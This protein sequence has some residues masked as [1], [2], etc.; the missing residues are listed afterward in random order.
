MKP[1][2][3]FTGFP[4]FATAGTKTYPGDTKNA[5]GFVP[6]DTFPA[7]WANYLFYRASKNVT[8]LN[9]AVSSIWTELTNLLTEWGI[10][11]TEA[12]NE[13]LKTAI[14]KILPQVTE[15]TTA[16]ATGAKSITIANDTLKTGKMYAVTFSNGNE[17]GDGSSTYPTLSI[18]GGTAYPMYDA[19][20]NYLK[21]GS[22]SAGATLNLVFTGTKFVALNIN[23]E[24]SVTE[25][26][27]MPVTSNAVAKAINISDL[28][29]PTERWLRFVGNNH[30]ALKIIKGVSIKVGIHTFTTDNDVIFDL[31]SQELQGG[32]NY[33][34]YLNWASGNVWSLTVDTNKTADT[35][36]SRLIGRFHTLCVSVSANQT[37]LLPT[38]TLSV[39]ASVNTSPYA[40]DDPD[41]VEFYTKSVISCS[42]D[43]QLY[44]ST[45]AHPLAGF[46]AGDILPEAVWCLTFKPDTKYEDA[47]FYDPITGRAEDIYLQSGIGNSTRSAYNA[48]HAVSR[49]QWNHQSDM[50]AVGKRL[51]KD[52]EFTACSLGSPQKTNIAGSSDKTTVGGHSDTGGN[53]MISMWGA[54][55]CCGYLWQ[56]LEEYIHTDTS[57]GWHTED[58]STNAPFGQSYWTVFA[59]VAGGPWG[60]GAICGSRCRGASDPRSSVY[61]SVGGRGSSLVKRGA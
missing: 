37:M 1:E 26:N 53:R 36:D 60:S 44:K 30:K 34:V 23:V 33:Y 47:M 31:T 16:A 10:T 13:Q 11:P 4:P 15:C 38:E 32:T 29:Y 45:F 57:T 51:L 2:S 35:S 5:A 12:S 3:N 42:A 59:L 40:D 55:E 61:P 6:S 22:W 7:E 56:W 20:G 21:E 24:D 50:L 46:S 27:Y 48:T 58:D 18:N 17:Y 8:E 41:F 25:G 54:E 52:F 19:L 28:I 14:A 49:T 43:G 9:A 39:G